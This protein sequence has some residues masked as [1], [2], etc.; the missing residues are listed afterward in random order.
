MPC[1]VVART[2]KCRKLAI[3]VGRARSRSDPVKL[4]GV[5]CGKRERTRRAAQETGRGCVG[6]RRNRTGLAINPGSW[7]RVLDQPGG[8]GK[9]EVEKTENGRDKVEEPETVGTR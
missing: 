7:L 8:T 5:C 6:E 1:T 9:R 3:S 4:G 2:K